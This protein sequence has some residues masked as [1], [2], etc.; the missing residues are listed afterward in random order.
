MST[1]SERIG[2][3][4]GATATGDAERAVVRDYGDVAREYEALRNGAMLVDRSDRSRMTFA[5][6]QALQTLGGLVTNDVA[7]LA[8]GEG[9]YA[10]ALTP[11][12]K[13]LADV[14]VFHL[15][16]TALVDVPPRAAEGWTAM[17]RKYVNPRLARYTDVSAALDD[18]G[19]FG[20]NSR[21]IVS[22]LT[23]IPADSLHALP[24]YS[25]LTA[26]LP[27][28]EVTVF[29]SPDAG[30]EGYELFGD[31]ALL[32]AL[33]S[34]AAEAGAT[35]AGRDA[36]EVVRIEAGRPEWGVDMSDATLPQ[37]ANLDELHAISY[38]KGCYT[39]QETVARIHFRGHVNKHLRALRSTAPEPLPAD[40][41]LL[42]DT[43][44]A[45]GDVRSAT[46]S[47]RL[48]NIAI[49]MVRREIEPGT[50]LPCRWPGGGTEVTV[51]PLPFPI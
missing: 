4:G 23:G 22:E 9:Q 36:W 34:G 30:L 29:R 1:S 10:A 19:I 20:A 42:D 26:S 32:R 25:Q 7:S 18:V 41:Q 27:D 50:T 43:G 40:A 38:T 24:S 37:E 13:I 16:D 6:A 49:G 5:G 35:P 51:W 3:Q 45:V 39:G 44:R 11:K 48:G 28:G 15:A 8:P 17:I 31:R 46:L 21:R 33:W 14:R 12:G 47:P 2:D